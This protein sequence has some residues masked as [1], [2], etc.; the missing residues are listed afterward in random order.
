MATSMSSR[1]Q[2]SS[3]VGGDKSSSKGF[4]FFGRKQSTGKPAP[5]TSDNRVGI[6]S[7]R[8]LREESADKT[9]QVVCQIQ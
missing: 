9:P 8:S 2:L 1:E 6:F 4:L 5:V 3:K 7:A